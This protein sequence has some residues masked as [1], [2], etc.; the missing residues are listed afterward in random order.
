MHRHRGLRPAAGG[1]VVPVPP[2]MRCH[3]CD[4]VE[5]PPPGMRCPKCNG[6]L[7]LEGIGTEQLEDILAASFPHA[8]VARLDRDVA[9]GRETE[10][11][12]SRM[13][14]REIDILVGTQMVTKGHDL[15]FVT[16][17]GVVN[18]DGALSMPDFR[19]AERT[20]H[21]LVQVA[22][23]AGRGDA[24]GQVLVQTRSPRHAAIECAA[25]HDV[26]AFIERELRDREELG[27]PPF[28][29][30]V[31][32]RIDGPN[33]ERT[34]EAAQRLADAALAT[35]EVA[36]GRVEVR[37]P[38]PA[39]VPRVRGR[40]RWRVLLRGDRRDVRAAAIAVRR[41]LEKTPRDVRA[42]V[43]VDPLSMM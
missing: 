41:A 35:P 1:T 8:R 17:V 31:L 25:N 2:G 16:L 5:P 33:E 19:A 39:P 27:Y 42:L 12:L 30:L 34:I 14:A 29:R 3:Y 13:R 4:R 23:R 7:A 21:L 22:G 28:S 38:S 40:F 36:S 6:P 10:A 37:G 43:D 9:G 20:F 18:A 26:D 24:R 15:P 32:V 11:I